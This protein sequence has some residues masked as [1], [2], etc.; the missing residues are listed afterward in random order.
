MMK[1]IEVTISQTLSSIQEI[2]V[3]EGLEFDNEEALKRYVREQIVLPSELTDTHSEI[4]W[5]V[6]DFCVVI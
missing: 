3:P 2:E 4:I 6:D 5:Y 1:T